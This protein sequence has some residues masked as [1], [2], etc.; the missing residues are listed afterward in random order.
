MPVSRRDFLSTLGLGGAG[1]VA[2]P[3]LGA[4]A[5]RGREADAALGRR[6]AAPSL[7]R[8]DSNENPN[9]PGETAVE[10]MRAMFG[11][12][13]RYPD[14]GEE[15]LMQ[16]IARIHGVSPANVV[17][18]CGS[19]EVLRNCVAAFT[20]PERALVT[21]SPT[22][23]NPSRFAAL[24][25][26]PVIAVPVDGQ[27]RLDLG[28]MAARAHGAGLVFVCNPNNPTA[29]VHGASTIEGFVAE[30]HRASPETT[31]LL[32]E[33]YHEY[34]SDASYRS[35]IPAAVRDPRLIVS[36]TFSKVF[37]LAGMRAGYAI[38]HQETAARL[39][40][41]RVGSGVNQLVAAAANI[42]VQDTRH[43]ERE[44]RDNAAARAFTMQWFR[45]AGYT[46]G[47][48]ETNFI[49]VDLRRD[50][51][52]VRAAC[53]AMG[54]AVGRPFPPLTNWLRISIGTLSEMHQATD[55]F[56]RALA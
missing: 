24:V 21:A 1:L 18:G 45:D 37:G 48:S 53:R 41:F 16:T 33:A 44:Q 34:V 43:I 46:V 2:A 4:F 50:P 13:N 23:E 36:R 26:H 8:L 12:S 39:E 54:V 40:G 17:L 47:A 19:T 35:A 56:K 29:T 11:E 38:A 25:G 42:S 51:A 32:D 22:F 27:L 6:G 49:M 9:G 55:V 52:P 3:S 14:A 30:V 20:S 10:A 28:Q 5:A 7:I 15:L 31:I